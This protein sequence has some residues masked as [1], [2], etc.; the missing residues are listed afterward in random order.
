MRVS[1]S[2]GYLLINRSR[3]WRNDRGVE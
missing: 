2:H 3:S 1:I